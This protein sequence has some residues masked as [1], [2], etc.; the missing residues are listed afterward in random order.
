MRQHNEHEKRTE[1]LRSCMELK[2]FLKNERTTQDLPVLCHAANISF[3]EALVD[4]EQYLCSHIRLYTTNCMDSGT[5][6]PVESQNSIVKEKLGVSGKMDIH[7]VVEK[8]LK[9]LIGQSSHKRKKHYVY[10]NKQIWHQSL[11]AKT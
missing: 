8:L 2:A 7:K 4:K 10:I 5:T 9:T 3:A 11:P 6:S 1:Y